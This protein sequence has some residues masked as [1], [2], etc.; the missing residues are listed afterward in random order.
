[1]DNVD[2]SFSQRSEAK[3][4]EKAKAKA[5]AKEI[6]GGIKTPPT[7]RTKR[8]AGHLKLLTAINEV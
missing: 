2:K 5:K 6:V 8:R 4:K 7:A 3:A 1:V